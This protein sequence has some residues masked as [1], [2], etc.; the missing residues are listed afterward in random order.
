M[1]YNLVKHWQVYLKVQ[2]VSCGPSIRHTQTIATDNILHIAFHLKNG[3]LITFNL[4]VLNDFDRLFKNQIY[5]Q[6]IL[7][8]RKLSYQIR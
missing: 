1:A 2:T 6:K 3:Y 7:S 5:K 4:Y 8:V